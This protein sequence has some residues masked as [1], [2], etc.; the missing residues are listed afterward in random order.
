MS[1]GAVAADR[2][3]VGRQTELGRRGA[4]L[5]VSHEDDGGPAL[6]R[7]ERDDERRVPAGD[8]DDGHA[9]VGED[10]RRAVVETAERVD[11]GGVKDRRVISPPSLVD[12]RPVEWTTVR[13]EA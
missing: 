4:V 3:P 2:L 10:A 1:L 8:S 9:D 5:A 12:V 11:V 7:V 6:G 13:T